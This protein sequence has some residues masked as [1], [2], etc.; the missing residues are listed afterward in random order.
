[1]LFAMVKDS[2]GRLVERGLEHFNIT[3]SGEMVATIEGYLAELERWN[4]RVNL[5]GLK[6]ASSILK[7]LVYDAFFLCTRLS[8]TRSLM[9]L[10]SGGGILAIPLKILMPS[11][12]VYPVDS[13]GKKIQFQ[14]HVRRTLHLE[15]FFPVQGRVE[16]IDPL[17]VDG[18]A[19]KAF[20]STGDILDKGQRHV[21]AGGSI[22]I[23]KGESEDTE[24]HEGFDLQ[25]STVYTLPE[26]GKRHRLLVY[27][28]RP[29]T[30]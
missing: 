24:A 1:M 12:L 8:G 6:D 14:N 5:V 26:S 25:D 30:S 10:G 21:A 17:N 27:R 19:A 28:K 20:G 23:L 13:N 18:L 29:P 7:D 22:F 2:T 4:R 11:L 9:D 15:G 3:F 16:E